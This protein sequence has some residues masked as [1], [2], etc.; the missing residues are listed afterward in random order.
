MRLLRRKGVTLVELLVGVVMLGIFAVGMVSAYNM[1]SKGVG[2]TK[3]K[4]IASNLLQEKIEKL[5]DYNYYRLLV[6]PAAALT[7]PNDASNPFPPE[8]I[9]VS[10][11]TYTRNTIV[12]KLLE[13]TGTGTLSILAPTDPDD[14]IKRIEV[15]L[16][17][18]ENSQ[19]KSISLFNLFNNPARTP[20][21]G[22][23]NG[24]VKNPSSANVSNVNVFVSDNPNLYSLTDASGNYSFRA[25]GGTYVLRADKRGYISQITGSITL[26][27]GTTV[28]TNFTGYTQKPTGTASG[29]VYSRNHLVISEVCAAVSG[30]DSTQFFE[31]YNP[32]STNVTINSSNTK[33]HYYDTGNN[34]QE[35]T[36]TWTGSTLITSGGYFLVASAST[37]SGVVADAY[38]S[39]TNVINAD[40]GGLGIADY[41][42]NWIDRVAWSKTGHTAPAG[43]TEGSAIDLTWFGGLV[44]G[45][46]LERR[47][48]PSPASP[49]G[50]TEGN[51]YD[52]EDNS[53]DFHAHLTAVPQ[54]CSSAAETP[55]SGSVVT[56]AYVFSTD[57][58]SSPS[59]S[60]STGTYT[61][62]NVAVGTWK[63]AAAGSSYYGELTSVTILT[64]ATTTAT[65]ILTTAATDGYITGTVT[66]GATTP[67]S[68]ITM[69]STTTTSTD[70]NGNYILVVPAGANYVTANYLNANVNYTSKSSTTPITVTAGTAVSHI[71]FNLFSGG[72]ISGSVTT[73]GTDPL[74]YVPIIAK[75]PLNIERGNALSDTSGAYTITNLEVTGFPYTVFPALDDKEVG[76][77][78]SI[79]A[80]VVAGTTSGGYNFQVTTG[81]ANISGTVKVSA[82]NKE[83][84]TGVLIVATTG[85]ISTTNPPTIDYTIRTG[86][87]I[88]YSTTSDSNGNYTMPVRGNAAGT[89]YNI[90]GWYT[91]PAGT[92]SKGT[93]STT[94]TSGASKTVNF[95]F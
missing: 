48:A 73:N 45:L 52:S 22:V 1:I 20:Q 72:A 46:V 29:Y 2:V 54:N 21:D 65:V 53:S 62:T 81:L 28:T 30:V 25:P 27:T 79:S 5:K 33:M 92:T 78:S 95:G 66:T 10:G 44:P 51:A 93:G 64:S 67:L 57:D 3:S 4:T 68:G 90:Y 9:T 85:S 58:V 76:T 16:S 19:A 86:S 15:T 70:V 42:G 40:K 35:F 56:G 14:G 49:A 60:T 69:Y 94:V 89:A 75:D 88:Y 47:Q 34:K 32:K 59:T 6:T 80:T 84:T 18:T 7:N 39:E 13:D 61:I 26:A 31:I 37:V 24:N 91:S 55:V 43:G 8:S 41:S 77:P 38:W 82:T 83:I 17:W 12:R 36:L 74:P 23:I 71:D 87:T 11:I 50:T 63:I